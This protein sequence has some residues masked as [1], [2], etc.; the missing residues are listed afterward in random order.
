MLERRTPVFT[1]I[2]LL[3]TTVVWILL[4]T[5]ALGE[6]MELARLPGT[7]LLL[8]IG[9]LLNGVVGIVAGMREERRGLELAVGGIILWIVTAAI[10]PW[11][12]F[13]W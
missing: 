7:V 8:A 2:S 11:K 5:L 12:T 1:G 3:I 6:N 4:L 10:L 13:H 9:G